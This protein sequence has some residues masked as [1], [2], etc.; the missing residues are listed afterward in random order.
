M[1]TR[2]RRKADRAGYA[3]LIVMM[4]ILTTTALAAVHTRHLNSALRVEQARL[5][6]ESRARGPVTVLAI[7][8]QRLETGDP[9][10]GDSFRYTHT[11]GLEYRVTYT[12]VSSNR[13]QV[14]A[15]PDSGATALVMLPD[16][17]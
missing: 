14:T 16:S 3:M 12:E 9:V 1:K 15:D 2:G 17:F 13:W 4:L 10:S 6:S 8:C 7:A 11:D 5:R